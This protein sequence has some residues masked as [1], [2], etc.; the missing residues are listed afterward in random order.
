LPNQPIEDDTTRATA[1]LPGLE[2]EIIHR[3]SPGADAEQISI[4]LQAVPSFEAFG[5]FQAANPFAFWVQAAQMAWLP[6]LGAARTLMLPWSGHRKSHQGGHGRAERERRQHQEE[7]LDDALKNTFPASDPVSIVQPAPPGADF[8][9]VKTSG[10]RSMDEREAFWAAVYKFTSPEWS[11]ASADQPTFDVKGKYLT[12][13]QV[14]ELVKDITEELPYL[15][16]GEVMKAMHGDRGLIQ[17][18][19]PSRTYATGSQC[20]LQLLED[21]IAR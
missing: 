4:H 9:S 8:D 2:I 21:R 20:V 19:A 12:I 5:R 11:P 7:A 13:R 6:W 15:V 14:C 3:R 18:F 16:A 17:L 1:H 10:T